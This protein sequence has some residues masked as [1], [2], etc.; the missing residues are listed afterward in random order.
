MTHLISSWNEAKPSTSTFMDSIS[1][2]KS[3]IYSL[4]QESKDVGYET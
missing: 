2:E 1:N 4:K 3:G